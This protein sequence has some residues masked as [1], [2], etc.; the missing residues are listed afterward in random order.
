MLYGFVTIISYKNSALETRKS[1]RLKAS[2]YIQLVNEF[3][4]VFHTQ[5]SATA[6]SVIHIHH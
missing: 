1:D 3:C 6:A 2:G 5:H 4:S